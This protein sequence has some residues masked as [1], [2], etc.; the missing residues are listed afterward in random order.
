MKRENEKQTGRVEKHIT[1]AKNIPRNIV[2]GYLMPILLVFPL[3]LNAD[4][5]SIFLLRFGIGV[6][7]VRI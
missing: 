5:G 1:N 4:F 7:C 2:R 6:M 3:T